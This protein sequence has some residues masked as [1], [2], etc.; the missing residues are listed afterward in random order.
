MAKTVPVHIH[1]YGQS[2]LAPYYSAQGNIMLPQ[3]DNPEAIIP[4]PRPSPS[5]GPS[6][7]LAALI[8]QYPDLPRFQSGAP[9][10]PNR[11]PNYKGKNP[12]PSQGQRRRSRSP[13]E[14]RRP[15]P[16]AEEGFRYQSRKGRGPDGRTNRQ[17][18]TT[19]AILGA[20][21]RDHNPVGHSN[22]S[23]IPTE[24]IIERDTRR[25]RDPVY[26]ARLR[27]R[28]H[29]HPS[30]PTRPSRDD[31]T[32]SRTNPDRDPRGTRGGGRDPEG[33]DRR[34]ESRRDR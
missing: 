16:G 15:P 24:E 11:N 34:R 20:N 17:H 8:K 4:I 30:G 32:D 31:D 7:S 28:E 9:K 14:S 13:I 21:R 6:A 25:E 18:I 22:R 19:E 1:H 23:R 3:L 10:H 5:E 2:P 33:R 12:R 26:E 27:A 29:F